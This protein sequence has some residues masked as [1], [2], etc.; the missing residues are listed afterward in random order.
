MKSINY[1]KE[2]KIGVRPSNL[3]VRQA[4]EIIAK[5]ELL[6][7][8]RARFTIKKYY[9]YG[10]LDKETSI[11]KIERSNFFTN[12]VD[13]AV[14]SGDVDFGVHSAKDLPDI[15][16]NGLRIACITKSI[17]RHDA[18]VSRDNLKLAELPLYS[19]I[20]ASSTRRKEQLK[21]FRSDFEIVDIRGNIEERLEKFEKN[22]LD[23]L[24]VATCALVRL[25]LV[26]RITA[27]I[28]FN[29]LEPHPLQGS[30]AI[31]VRE[32]NYEFA[33]KFK[34]IN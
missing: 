4:E 6:G 29:I 30:L 27:E 16:P 10:D 28:P 7:F 14:L 32:D 22:K 11:S 13:K 25:G 33:E 9:T 20:G 3:A 1:Y 24:I 18:L 34:K 21:K 26:D 2:I 17:N 19:K 31:I 23:G 5:L 12:T 8:E 15:I